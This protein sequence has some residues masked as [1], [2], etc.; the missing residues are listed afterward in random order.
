M[1]FY[2]KCYGQH[3]RVMGLRIMGD[4]CFERPLDNSAFQVE[5]ESSLGLKLAVVHKEPPRKRGPR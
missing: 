4:L 5:P 2:D 1:I 3:E